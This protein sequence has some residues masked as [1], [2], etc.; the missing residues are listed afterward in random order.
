MR[1]PPAE[2]RHH[3][4]LVHAVL[5]VNPRLL[6][7]LLTAA[8]LLPEVDAADGLMAPPEG[9]VV[10]VVRRGRVAHARQRPAARPDQREEE[11]P[12]RAIA[13]MPAQALLAVHLKRHLLV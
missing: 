3:A 1:V 7:N 12:W 4:G 6:A 10:V 5:V 8:A 11:R 9:A 2:P 13:V